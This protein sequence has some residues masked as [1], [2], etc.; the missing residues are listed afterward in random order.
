MKSCLIILTVLFS[1][2][3]SHS[4]TNSKIRVSILNKKLSISDTISF[5]V[6]STSYE[7]LKFSVSLESFLDN[8]W[9][10]IYSNIFEFDRDIPQS[11][12]L[13]AKGSKTLKFPVSLIHEDYQKLYNGN[14]FRLVIRAWPKNPL[15]DISKTS[16]SMFILK[17]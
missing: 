10:E 8:N 15:N 9:S 11:F 13:S 17:W 12:S 6:N 3:C 4:Q 7:A 2:F 5:R 1:S 14:K 16:S